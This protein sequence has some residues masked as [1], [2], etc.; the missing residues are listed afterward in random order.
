M[1]SYK[2]EHCNF[3]TNLK[4]N[5]NRHN[6]SRKHIKNIEKV[7]EIPC[8]Y[9]FLTPND[10]DLTP[11]DPDLTPNDP[12]LT[13]TQKKRVN[14]TQ[15]DFCNLIFSTKGHLSRHQK[16]SCVFLKQNDET[17]V[18]KNELNKQ[19]KMNIKL[20]NEK[21]MLY[22]QIEQLLEKVG[23]TTINQTQNI[24]LNNYG[25]EDLSH[26]TD[27]LKNELLTVPYCS[28]PKLIEHVHFNDNKPENKNI[29]L[30][31]IR[32]NKIKIFSGDKWVYKNKDETINDL[33]D[34]KYNIID[35]HFE[36]KLDEDEVKI[37]TKH[38]Y[39]KFRTFYDEKDK[40]LHETLKKQCELVLLNNR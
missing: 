39:E 10:P 38:N 1:V 31:N 3:A 16:N 15:C 18:L 5:F 21:K 27:N 35:T 37:K 9:S 20:E 2:C 32:D 12:D 25:N 4:Y 14:Y 11:N 17:L 40:Q 7:K 30:T 26:I 23:N 13:P 28:I 19:K 8:D 24:I 22:K 6:L 34:E 33:V 29:S 36:N